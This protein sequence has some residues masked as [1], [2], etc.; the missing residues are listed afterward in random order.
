[1]KPQGNMVSPKKWSMEWLFDKFETWFP[2]VFVGVA[3]FIALM[4]IAI[5]AAMAGLLMLVF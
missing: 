3:V 1:M 2:K 4:M 5:L